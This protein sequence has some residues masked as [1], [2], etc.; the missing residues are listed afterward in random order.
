MLPDNTLPRGPVQIILLLCVQPDV[1]LVVQLQPVHQTL[2]VPTYRLQTHLLR[3]L[4]VDRCLEFQV[5]IKLTLTKILKSMGE[6]SEE[7]RT[8]EE[9]KKMDI[10]QI[11]IMM[12]EVTTA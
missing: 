12:T 5:V 4:L 3:I 2:L 8:E 6:K 7:T 11:T 10:G 9:K 1:L